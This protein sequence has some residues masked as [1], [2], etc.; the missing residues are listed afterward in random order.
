[1]PRVLRLI[2]CPWFITA[3]ALLIRAGFVWSYQAH[4]PH[5]ALGAIPFLFESGNIAYSLARGHGF[6]SPLRIDTGPTAWMTP[7]YPM[8]LSG[9][10][11]V[12][13]IYTFQSWAAAVA[14][15]VCFSALV[16]VPLF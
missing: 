15:N 6:G 13:G 5:R 8:L 3:T 7:L 10:M 9:I 2:R 14:V 16:C 12:F 4:T 11:R 1:M